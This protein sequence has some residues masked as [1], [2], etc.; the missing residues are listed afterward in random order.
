M[1]QGTVQLA[2]GSITFRSIL[3]RIEAHVLAPR[4]IMIEAGEQLCWLGAACRAS[5]IPNC[6]SYYTTSVMESEDTTCIV[7]CLEIPAHE[8]E[9]V[10]SSSARCWTPLFRNPSIARGFPIAKRD[11]KQ[12]GL[13]VPINMMASLAGADRI[14][15][16]D[17][18]TMLKGFSTLLV[19]VK[20]IAS[21][22]IW[23]LVVDHDK[24]MS[25]NKAFDNITF[26]HRTNSTPS[27]LL[28]SRHF[29]G[30]VSS[31][32]MRAGQS[33]CSTLLW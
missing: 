22:V 29:V 27:C 20:S 9:D 8:A 11:D 26:P 32:R 3:N 18:Q 31:A 5:S 15:T 12:K 25:Y 6:R 19:P 16:F 14:T 7:Q 1:T 24:E 4:H 2:H 33:S 17:D 23:H 21:S 28:Q 10:S 13:E 30:W